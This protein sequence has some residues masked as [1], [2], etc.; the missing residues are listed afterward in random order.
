MDKDKLLEKA[1]H[2]I[3]LE[4][5]AVQATA[6]TLDQSFVDVIKDIEATVT[7]QK[8]IIFSG[9]GKN[10][11]ICQKLM[12]TF[13]ST[14]VPACFLDPNQALHGDI[15]VL[16]EGDLVF[17]LSNSGET[18][19]LLKLLPTI[20]RLGANVVGI[21][22]DPRSQLAQEANRTLVYQVPEE[23]CP[24]NL[25][26]TSSTAAALALGDALAMVY[27]EIRGFTR[28]DFAKLHPAGSLG[29][30]LL[31]R[32]NNIMRSG[33]KFATAPDTITVQEALI[34]ITRAKCGAIALVNPQD[35]CLSGVFTDGDFRRCT[36]EGNDFI[37]ETIDQFMH[38]NPWTVRS[39]S[40]AIDA[41][42]IFEE[43]KVDEL[44]V[45]DST[46]RPIGLIDLQDFP[47]LKLI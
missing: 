27:L 36:L 26:P 19:E 4:I 20:K 5:E 46:N 37:K 29:K 31:L 34:R 40:L 18:E 9:V 3:Q 23:A 8:K 13:N 25:A 12:G 41:L 21:T 39:D 44:I 32:V 15:G 10:A 14:G 33:D 43:S 7:Q 17:L 11:A 42:K 24:L 38:R 1:R 47:K 35:G 22:A 45:I 2:C 30:T 6:D 28:E 16:T